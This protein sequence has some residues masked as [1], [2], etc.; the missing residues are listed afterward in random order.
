MTADGRPEGRDLSD[1]FSAACLAAYVETVRLD[2]TKISAAARLAAESDIGTSC[3][4]RTFP[5]AHPAASVATEVDARD[6]Y[7][8]VTHMTTTANTK[9]PPETCV[10]LPHA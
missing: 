6:L 4:G 8:P 2:F 5:A 9:R 7:L 10:S 3:V 1:I